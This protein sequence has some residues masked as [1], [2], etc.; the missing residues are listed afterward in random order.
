MTTTEQQMTEHTA[1]VVRKNANWLML[2]GILLVVLGVIGLGMEVSLTIGSVLFFGFLI[3]AG[4]ILQLIDAFKA[5]GWK[6]VLYHIL[7]ALLYIAAGIIMITNPLL[8]AVWMTMVIAAVLIV[9]GILRIVMGLQLRPLK[10]WGW[11][12]AAGVAAIVLGAMIFA[13]WPASGLWVIGLF[14]AIEL[15]MQGWAM[16][17]IAMAAKASTESV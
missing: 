15:I 4:G 6:S 12:V 14:I 9:V 8:G 5:E 11:T 16:I 7:I 1:P 3:L 10:G 2:L 13:Q 17:A